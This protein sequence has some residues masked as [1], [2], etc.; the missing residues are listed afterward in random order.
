[1]SCRDCVFRGIFQDMGASCDV[2]N[3]HSDLADA[4]KACENPAGCRHRFTVEEA[5]KIV[6]EREGGLPVIAREKTEPSEESNPL[7]IIND[8]F[9]RIAESARIALNSL[10][11]V[12]KSLLE[13]R[14]CANCGRYGKNDK[15]CDYCIRAFNNALG[16]ESDPSHWIPAESE[17]TE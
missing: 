15:N 6:I 5:R 4:I 7:A 10:A 9:A 14:D 2:C 13:K 8:A 16:V 12:S 11:G 17:A 1:M 3:L